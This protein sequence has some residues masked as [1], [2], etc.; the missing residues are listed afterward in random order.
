MNTI[1]VINSL[2]VH[3]FSL[4]STSVLS[5]AMSKI[6]HKL[7][8]LRQLY[9]IDSL[10]R[11]FFFISLKFLDGV[12]LQFRQNYGI[13]TTKMRQ[14]TTVKKFKA[15][16]VIFKTKFII[17]DWPVAYPGGRGGVC[18]GAEASPSFSILISNFTI[19]LT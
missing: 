4:D 19:S 11:D 16:L 10:K 5:Y 13:V 8:F 15:N 14:C 7:V 1:L 3:F 12:L 6:Q 17:L 2:R 18:F 9:W